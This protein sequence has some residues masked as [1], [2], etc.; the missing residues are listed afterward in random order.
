MG[1]KGFY[2]KFSDL[3]FVVL[4]YIAYSKLFHFI[5]MI[6]LYDKIGE[7]LVLCSVKYLRY[8]FIKTFAVGTYPWY[9]NNAQ[10]FFLKKCWKR[11]F[12]CPYVWIKVLFPEL[13]LL[14]WASFNWRFR[15]L[16]LFKEVFS[17]HRSRSTCFSY[18]FFFFL[19]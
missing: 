4:F 11:N 16:N 2:Y 9:I 12:D 10:H 6:F 1:G 8:L 14:K 3:G 18:S 13:L 19:A 15:R 7:I 5:F 17:H